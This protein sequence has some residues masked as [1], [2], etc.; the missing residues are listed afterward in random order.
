M[1]NHL[2]CI[3]QVTEHIGS[4]LDLLLQPVNLVTQLL[5][6]CFYGLLEPLFLGGI[7]GMRLL[8]ELFNL[9]FKLRDRY[10]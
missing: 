5:L 1:G 4:V 8:S 2:V 6:E 7:G 10:L 9:D 3:L